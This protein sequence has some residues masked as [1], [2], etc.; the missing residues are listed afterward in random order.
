M[1]AAHENETSIEHVPVFIQYNDEEDWYWRYGKERLYKQVFSS[2]Q[3]PQS[4]KI[5][6]DQ[7]HCFVTNFAWVDP[8]WRFL[9]DK[10]CWPLH[11][12]VVDLVVMLYQGRRAYEKNQ[13]KA[14]AREI[15]DVLDLSR[16]LS[17]EVQ[18]SLRNC[19]LETGTKG[20][21]TYRWVH[22]TCDESTRVWIRSMLHRVLELEDL[23]LPDSPI[24]RTTFDLDRFDDLVDDA[25]AKDEDI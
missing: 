23:P 19:K 10:P 13:A 6:W 18:T 24:M 1:E 15:M 22:H 25:E 4:D 11:I 5:S 12:D 14:G 7:L 16:R 17:E 20:S 9:L 8:K 3:N 21:E 2:G